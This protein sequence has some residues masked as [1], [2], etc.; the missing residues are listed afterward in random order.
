MKSNLITK[1]Q[2][3]Y[4]QNM[5]RLWLYPIILQ[6][7][8]LKSRQ[9]WKTTNLITMVL[10][11][12]MKLQQMECPLISLSLLSNFPSLILT[13][14]QFHTKKLKIQSR[15]QSM[16]SPCLTTLSTTRIKQ[17][18]NHC[19]LI[20]Q[21]NPRRLYYRSR[22]VVCLPLL[23]QQPTVS[24]KLT[25]RRGKEFQTAVKLVSLKSI[26]SLIPKELAQ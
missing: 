19:I 11:G 23:E 9:S 26:S 12:Q 2:H 10:S 8:T 7:S 15:R 1:R 13:R 18:K 3:S 4:L 6:F 5:K 24:T 17:A 25:F 14:Y 21:V 20:G 22:L 16:I